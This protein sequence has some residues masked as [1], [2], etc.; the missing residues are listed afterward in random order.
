MMRQVTAVILAGG[1]GQRIGGNKALQL[2]RGRPLIDWVFDAVSKQCDEVLVNANADP[3]A[4]AHLTCPVIADLTPGF[5]GPLAGLQA[6]MSSAAHEW[7]ACIPCDTPFLPEELIERLYMGVTLN[8][9]EA[10]VV[11]V[12]GER[13]PTAALF[14]RSVLPQLDAYLASGERRVGGFLATLKLYEVEFDDAAAFVN[15]NTQDDLK[16][17]NLHD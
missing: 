3:A 6:A 7:I 16:E 10:A 15:I 8:Q 13:Q 14:H 12:A 17:F 1:L 5:A 9:C 11:V 2:L 4:Y